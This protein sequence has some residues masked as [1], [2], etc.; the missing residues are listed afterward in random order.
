MPCPECNFILTLKRVKNLNVLEYNGECQKCGWTG[1]FRQI[2]CGRC[3]D[4][5]LFHWKDNKWSC[6][7]CGHTRYSSP[8]KSNQY[9]PQSDLD[10]E[11][12]LTF[13]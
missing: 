9:I 2:R 10:N 1:I 3:H 11:A 13:Q 4:N 8:P 12:H 5:R 6:F 7:K